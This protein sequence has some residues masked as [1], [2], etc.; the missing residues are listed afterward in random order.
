MEDTESEMV[1][2]WAPAFENYTLSDTSPSTHLQIDIDV[3]PEWEEYM[4]TA[5]PKALATLKRLCEDGKA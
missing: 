5:W 1:R 4:T 3:A 2:S